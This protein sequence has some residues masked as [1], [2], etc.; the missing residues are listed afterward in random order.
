MVL[1][2]C[3]ERTNCLLSADSPICRSKYCCKVL[4]WSYFSSLGVIY[5]RKLR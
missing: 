2:M 1:K 4:L 5:S 3:L